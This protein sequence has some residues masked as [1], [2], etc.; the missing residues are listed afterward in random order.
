M[1]RIG[2]PLVDPVRLVCVIH[3]AER[4]VDRDRLDFVLLA[5][6][7]RT[8]GPEAAHEFGA[9]SRPPPASNSRYCH[10]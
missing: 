8:E 5:H 9:A 3:V 2:V 6:R 7:R 1:I 4:I 10:R